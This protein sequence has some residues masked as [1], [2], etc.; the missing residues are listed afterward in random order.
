[1][2]PVFQIEHNVQPQKGGGSHSLVYLSV[3]AAPSRSF[4][5]FQQVHCPSEPA[6][7]RVNHVATVGKRLR[8]LRILTVHRN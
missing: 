7:R 5:N 6:D 2:I 1:M 4:P 3:D 8:D